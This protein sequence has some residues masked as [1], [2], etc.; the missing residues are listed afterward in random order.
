M[1]IILTAC[2]LG[3]L[4]LTPSAN[5]SESPKQTDVPNIFLNDRGQT[6]PGTVVFQFNSAWNSI[7]E[8]KWVE[9][10][11]AKYFEVDIDKNPKFKIKYNIKSLPTIIIFKNGQEVKRY[12]GGLQMKITTPIQVIQKDL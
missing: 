7:N 3:V 1:K 2:L 6:I 9:T 12:E 5:L 4:L 8:Y 11:K 10:F